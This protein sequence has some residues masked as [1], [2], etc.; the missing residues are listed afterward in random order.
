MFYFRRPSPENPDNPE[1]NKISGLSEVSGA[2]R[3]K[4]TSDL[5]LAGQY[6]LTWMKNI[7]DI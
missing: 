2:G 5:D 1:K 6:A 3:Q 7:L 4:W